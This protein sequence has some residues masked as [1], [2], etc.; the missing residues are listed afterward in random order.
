MRG[1]PNP[2]SVAPESGMVFDTETTSPSDVEITSLSV[3][4][5][6]GGWRSEAAE[7]VVECVQIQ[8]KWCL[9]RTS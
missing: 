5:V 6:E 7:V 2:T 1:D 8:T 4:F 3:V 9:C